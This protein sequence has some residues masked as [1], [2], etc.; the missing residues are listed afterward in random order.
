[1]ASPEQN[2]EQSELG[3]AGKAAID[4]ERAARR[5]AEKQLKALQAEM[6]QQREAQNAQKPLAE[7]LEAAKQELAQMRAQL[8]EQSLRQATVS[9]ATKL[10]YR[11]PDLA[12]RLVDAK[13]VQFDEDGT[14][15]N[16]EKLLADVAKGDSYLLTATDFG[17]GTR[18]SQPGGTGA[19]MNDLIRQA[20][21]R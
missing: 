12:Y 8:Q 15:T 2:G 7:Q 4:S 10:G 1:M 5:E 17:G 21:G 11:N 13:D 20:A 3:D 14:P 19:N 18:G 9:A 16:I 6:R